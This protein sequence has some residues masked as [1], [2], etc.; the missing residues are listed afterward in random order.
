MTDETKDLLE[1]DSADELEQEVANRP[2]A[3]V[4]TVRRDQLPRGADAPAGDVLYALHD[5]R[6]RPL[7]LFADRQ[8]AMIAARSHDYA[9]V[10]VH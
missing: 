4:R 7:A 6:G 3:Y 9:P 5:E 1:A 8:L 10:S 2:I